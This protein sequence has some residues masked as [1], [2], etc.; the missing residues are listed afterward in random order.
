[1]KDALKAGNCFNT[2]H[3]TFLILTS[4]MR[5]IK[6]IIFDL[7]GILINID[8]NIAAESFKKLGLTDFQRFFRQ[9]HVSELFS[10][11]ET[12]KI[13]PTEFYEQF[14]AEMG[15]NISYDELVMAWNSLLLDF[16]IERIN[17][18]KELRKKYNL[19][20]FSNTNQ[21]HY[22][23]FIKSF[24]ELTGEDFNSYF[25]KAY[26][27]HEIKMRKPFTEGFELI[28]REQELHPEETLFIDDTLANVEAAR[29]LGMEAIH[30]KPPMT[31]LDKKV[32]EKIGL[33]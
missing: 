19:F 11:L 29:S 14:I 4:R 27:S 28:L 20:L 16:P 26:Y 33:L 9:D 22:D 32:Q 3:L 1:M 12:G 2:Y 21:I 18:L 5:K 8:F 31:I 23:A 13:S 30:I 25:I 10:D 24:K 6:N 15:I 7:G 17:W